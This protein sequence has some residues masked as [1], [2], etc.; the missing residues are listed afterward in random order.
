MDNRTPSGTDRSRSGTEGSRT[1]GRDPL[2]DRLSRP[3]GSNQP[4]DPPEPAPRRSGRGGSGTV[5]MVQVAGSALAAVSAAVVSSFFG[6]AG[7]VIG[8]AVASIIATVGSA[9][10]SASLRRTNE[11]VR[12][13]TA[14][15]RAGSTGGTPTVVIPPLPSPLRRD[16]LV[17]SLSV[18]RRRWPA[19]AGAAVLVFVLAIGVLT[20]VESATR[21]PV[22]G[23]VGGGSSTGTSV[24]SLIGGSS[25]PSH[26]PTPA[27]GVVSPSQGPARQVPA[28]SSSVTPSAPIPTGVA[29]SPSPVPSSAAPAPQAPRPSRLPVAT[30]TP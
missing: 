3:A 6:V 25:T 26:R 21:Q 28:P 1:A 4:P 24:G 2:T 17:R 7:T 13:L 15:R 22:S 12:Q 5:S 27:P 23:L 18:L 14:T 19:V 30:P 29:P 10:Y 16:S 11:R 20:I 8:A 9:I